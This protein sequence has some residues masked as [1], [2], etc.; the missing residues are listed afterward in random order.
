M[1]NIIFFNLNLR[2]EIAVE[3]QDKNWKFCFYMILHDICSPKQ[4]SHRFFKSIRRVIRLLISI[5]IGL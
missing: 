4:I 3:Y 5:I 1:S 2:V